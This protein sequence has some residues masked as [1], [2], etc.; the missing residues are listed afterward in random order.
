[1]EVSGAYQILDDKKPDYMRAFLSTKKPAS[2]RAFS[3][4]WRATEDESWNWITFE[5]LRL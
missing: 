1:L 5:K 2:R 4:I 3:Y